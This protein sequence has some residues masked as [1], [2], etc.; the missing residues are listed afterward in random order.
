MARLCSVF[1]VF[2]LALCLLLMVETGAAAELY[3]DQPLHAEPKASA[4]VIGE[5]VHGKVVVVERRGFWVKIQSA[6]LTGWTKLSH[7]YMKPAMT[8][9]PPIDILRDTG[10]MA[11]G[12]E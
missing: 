4:D 11:V 12:K 8:W 7:V 10:R 2:K 1:G 6:S 5:A 3:S 9:M